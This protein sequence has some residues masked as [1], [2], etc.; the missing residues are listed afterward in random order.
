MVSCIHST[1]LL[2]ERKMYLTEDC[3][4]N[5]LNAYLECV[6]VGE[7]EKNEAFEQKLKEKQERNA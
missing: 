7:K 5:A 3:F 6:K 2:N 4:L 1:P